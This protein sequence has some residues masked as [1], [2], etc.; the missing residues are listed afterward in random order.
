MILTRDFTAAFTVD[1]IIKD[2]DFALRMAG[3]NGVRLMLP[4]LARQIFQEASSLGHGG[5][6]MAA[7]ILEMEN[8]AGVKVGGVNS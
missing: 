5:E 1:G 4:A 3:D 6:H 8:I 2:L 7:V